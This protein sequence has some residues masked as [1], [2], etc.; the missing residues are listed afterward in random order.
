MHSSLVRTNEDV[1]VHMPA[2]HS[3]L[4][5]VVLHWLVSVQLVPVSKKKS[6]SEIL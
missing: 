6:S 2:T 4:G 1:H 3:V 5:N